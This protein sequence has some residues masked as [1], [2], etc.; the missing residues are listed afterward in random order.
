M[1]LVLTDEQEMLREAAAGFLQEKAP[2][3]ALRALRD[4]DDPVGFDRGLWKDMA[5]MGWA[6]ILIDEDHGGSGFGFVGAGVIAQEMG[7]TLTASPF[8]STS[9]MAATALKRAGTKDQQDALLPAIASGDLVMALAVD[10]GQ[11][12]RPTQTDLRAEKSGNGFKLTG[13]KTFVADG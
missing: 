1:P 4:A 8:L 11:K 3:S 12:H 10:E 2:V 6:G 7:R 9:V 13:D 5:E